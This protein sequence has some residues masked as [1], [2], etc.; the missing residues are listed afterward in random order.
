LALEQKK[1]P[2]HNPGLYIFNYYYF[3]CYKT[4]F[5]G[6]KEISTGL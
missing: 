3:Y 5:F 1:F 6:D 2:N 4:M